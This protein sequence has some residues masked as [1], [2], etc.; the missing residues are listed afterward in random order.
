MATAQ[1]APGDTH[2]IAVQPPARICGSDEAGLDA[3]VQHL[4]KHAVQ[5]ID[6]DI[7]AGEAGSTELGLARAATLADLLQDMLSDPRVRHRRVRIFIRHEPNPP[8]SDAPSAHPGRDAPPPK[9][10]TDAWAEVRERID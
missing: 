7:Y 9:G 2:D 5:L 6:V 8:P 4:R 1:T 10:C 3:L